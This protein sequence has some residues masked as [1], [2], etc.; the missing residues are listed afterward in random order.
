LL[1]IDPTTLQAKDIYELYGNLA[2]GVG[3]NEEG[4]SVEPVAGINSR[5]EGF[6]ISGVNADDPLGVSDPADMYLIKTDDI[7]NTSSSCEEHVEIQ[8]DA[9]GWWPN[10]LSPNVSTL[11]TRTADTVGIVNMDSYDET[12][13]ASPKHISPQRDEPELAVTGLGLRIAL[14]P[15]PLQSGSVIRFL[16]GSKAEG[17]AVVRI[18]DMQGRVAVI[19]TLVIEAGHGEVGPVSLPSG[20]YSMTISMEGVRG[21][22]R[23]IITD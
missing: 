8:W 14:S 13:P 18:A 11:V 22:T 21:S 15:N 7:G 5:T 23:F 19:R 3:N 1:S 10:C 12:C 16:L 2:S 9:F 17:E 4:V 6:I 20:A